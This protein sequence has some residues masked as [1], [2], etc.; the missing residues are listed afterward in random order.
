M[1][2]SGDKGIHTMKSPHSER[3]DPEILKVIYPDERVF[4]SGWV[5]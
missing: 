4:D 2:Y 1:S 3:N 5:G